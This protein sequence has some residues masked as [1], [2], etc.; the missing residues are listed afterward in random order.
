MP[1]RRA[2]AEAIRLRRSRNWALKY[3]NRPPLSA[4]IPPKRRREGRIYPAAPG[5]LCNQDHR[6]FG[7]IGLS[8]LADVVRRR[9]P[10]SRECPSAAR[11][12]R[13]DRLTY[14]ESPECLLAHSD[15]PYLPY[16]FTRARPRARNV[17]MVESC[18]N[19]FVTQA[20]SACFEISGDAVVRKNSSSLSKNR[21]RSRD[22]SW[23]LSGWPAMLPPYGNTAA[24]SLAPCNFTSVSIFAFV[25]TNSFA[26]TLLRLATGLRS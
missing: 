10:C 13:Q 6:Y 8:S 25:A 14:G 16:S 11:L 17:D 22:G 26:T 15:A 23:I 24:R 4:Q 18:P 19:K 12:P 1:K 20:F 7:L 9:P 2:K 3:A 5:R 21:T